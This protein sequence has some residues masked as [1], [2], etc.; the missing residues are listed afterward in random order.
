[1]LPM[2]REAGPPSSSPGAASLLRLAEV[3]PVVAA[4]R[5]DREMKVEAVEAGLADLDLPAQQHRQELDAQLG[6]FEGRKGLRPETLCIAEFRAPHLDCE[7]GKHAEPELPLDREFAAGL[8]LDRL[9]DTVAVIVRVE[10]QR[11]NEDRD[12]RQGDQRSN[13]QEEEFDD[14][15][16]GLHPCFRGCL[17]YQIRDSRPISW[18]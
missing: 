4:V 2:S 16:H 5:A 12:D 11:E 18:K 7:P 15:A 13:E 3:L 17:A 10:Q 1:M 9:R 6:G 8:T 14:A